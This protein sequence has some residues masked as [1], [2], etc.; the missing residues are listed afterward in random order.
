MSDGEAGSAKG[1]CVSSMYPAIRASVGRLQC[2]LLLR[3]ANPFSFVS[4]YPDNSVWDWRFG[5]RV[6]GHFEVARAQ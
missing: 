3:S 6:Q 1:W 2:C 4:V 5:V